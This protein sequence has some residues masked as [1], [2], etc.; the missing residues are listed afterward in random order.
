VTHHLA[1]HAAVC[2]RV[3]QVVEGQAKKAIVGEKDVYDV[4]RPATLDRADLARAVEELFRS[5]NSHQDER[6][7]A[8]LA[9]QVRPRRGNCACYCAIATLTSVPVRTLSPPFQ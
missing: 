2:C 4:Q 5:P 6:V 3:S 9:S 8:G 1:K 7:V